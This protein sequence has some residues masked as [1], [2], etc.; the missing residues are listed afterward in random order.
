MALKIFTLSGTEDSP[1]YRRDGRLLTLNGAA[2]FSNLVLSLD[3]NAQEKSDL[4]AF[5]RCL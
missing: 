1:H 4:A 2:E 5:M 3:L